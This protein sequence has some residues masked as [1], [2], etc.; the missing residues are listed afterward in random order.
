MKRFITLLLLCLTTLSFTGC[1]AEAS[2]Y[3]I[4]YGGEEYTYE[5]IPELEVLIEAQ[6][7]VMNAAHDMAEAAR[8]LGYLEDNPVILT[9]KNEYVCAQ[10]A[11]LDIQLVIDGLETAFDASFDK[12]A[13]EYPA[14]TTVW[15]YL[16]SEG[17]NDYVCAG[18]M[19]NL[20]A[21]VG[22]QTLALN[23]SSSNG[24]YYGMCQWNK[25]YWEVWG[26]DLLSQCKFLNKTMKYEF[27]TY[28]SKYKN[29]FNFE[30]F[31]NLQNEEKAA[32]A[33]AKCYERCGSGSYKVR[34]QNAEKAYE[35]FVG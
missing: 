20:M 27:D 26:A 8:R 22:G 19:G 14:A 29:N 34:Q 31:K 25:A 16:K 2:T 13:K 28:G 9:A 5:D 10:Q 24:N 18:I 15:K 21:E 7:E 33:F 12:K 3:S 17:Y 32:L 30:D 1:S 4:E 11:M 35:Y 23:P 6:I